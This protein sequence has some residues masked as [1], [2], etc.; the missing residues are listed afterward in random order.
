MSKDEATRYAEFCQLRQAIRGS[1]VHLIVGIDVAKD[2]HHAFFGT[3]TGKTLLKRL[4]FDNTRVGFERLLERAGQLGARHGLGHVVFAL[5]PTGNYHKPLAHWLLAQNQVLVLVTN[6]AIAENRQTLDGRWDKN[7]TKDSANI[8]DLVS[9]GKCR[10]FEN[11]EE[12]L[13]ELRTLLSVR[14]RLKKQE[15]ALRMQ[16]RNGLLARYFPE[17]DRHWGSAITENMAIVRWCLSPR[18]IASLSFES[19]VRRVTR[20]D[21]GERQLRRLRTIYEAAAESVGCPMDA[22]GV[23]EARTLV[24]NFEDARRRRVACEEKIA[25]VAGCFPSYRRLLT[26]PGFGPYIAAQVL[27]RIG[28]P[29][30]FQSR[31]QVIRLA[32]LDLNAKRSGRRSNDAVPVITKRGNGELRYALYQAARVASYHHD[33]FRALLARYLEG[34]EKER[35]I[36]T[37][38]LVK[39]AEKMLVIAWTLMRTQ[40]DFDPKMLGV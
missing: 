25:M 27:A 8:A 32:G 9:Q 20:R 2:R 6:H 33:G 38:R 12:D 13:V 26:I 16:I 15:H 31:R 3:A 28:D 17:L 7:D 34:R 35:G 10:F 19:F 22:A 40:R 36:V 39:L 23:F 21:G 18:L 30:R 11:P 29:H 24:D 14:K 37:K 5:E 1:A 4:L